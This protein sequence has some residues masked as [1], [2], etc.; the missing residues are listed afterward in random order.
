MYRPTRGLGARQQRVVCITE[1]A[2]QYDMADI[3]QQRCRV[4]DIGKRPI[5]DE[6][7]GELCPM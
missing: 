7:T 1:A 5:A 2:G 4:A 3:N 6:S